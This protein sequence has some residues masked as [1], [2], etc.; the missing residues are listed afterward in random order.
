[1]FVLRHFGKDRPGI[2]HQPFAGKFHAQM[3]EAAANPLIPFLQKLWLRPHPK[4]RFDSG[5][6]EFG[7]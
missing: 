7:G 3:K 4:L 6:N 1:M 5:R 2:E